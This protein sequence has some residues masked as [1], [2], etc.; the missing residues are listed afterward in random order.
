MEQAE[1][2]VK[3]LEER[4]MELMT[5][6]EE[7]EAVIAE[8]AVGLK[9]TEMEIAKKVIGLKSQQ[10]KLSTEARAAGQGRDAIVTTLPDSAVKIYD[11]I[12]ARRAGI[13]VA[14]LDNSGT[15]SGCQIELRPQQALEVRRLEKLVQCPQ[16]LRIL[17]LDSMTQTE[18]AS[19]EV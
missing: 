4:V 5:E 7:K 8:K 3:S 18:Q 13:A 16:C 19:A 17:I 1:R 9:E 12:R 14:Q 15:C 11:R 6:I 10:I 2:V